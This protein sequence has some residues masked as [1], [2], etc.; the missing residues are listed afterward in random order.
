MDIHI[1]M[2]AHVEPL[3]TVHLGPQRYLA[4]LAASSQ[5]MVFTFECIGLVWAGVLPCGVKIIPRHEQ[6]GSC[7][8]QVPSLLHSKFLIMQRSWGVFS[9]HPKIPGSRGPA[10]DKAGGVLPPLEA[11]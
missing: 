9:W 10:T 4:Q 6:S 3:C 7:D 5:A 1:Q 11:K 8:V 2:R